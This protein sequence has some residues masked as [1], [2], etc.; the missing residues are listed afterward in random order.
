M[1]KLISIGV[2]PLIIFIF[3]LFLY[4]FIYISESIQFRNFK[5]RQMSRRS[6][7]P[8]KRTAQKANESFDDEYTMKRQRNNAAVNKTRQKKRQEEVD[9]VKRVQ[10]LREENLALERSVESLRNELGLLKEMVLSFASRSNQGPG[11]ST[12]TGDQAHPS[13]SQKS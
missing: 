8:S 1:F 7:R 4:I 5:K 13:G 2:N 9:T 12:N 3:L 10:E 11:T 6:D